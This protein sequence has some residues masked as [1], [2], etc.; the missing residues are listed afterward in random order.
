MDKIKRKIYFLR[1]SKLALSYKDHEAMPFKVLDDLSTSR[2][3]PGIDE[4]TTKKLLIDLDNKND[5]SQVRD[6]YYNSSDFQSKRSSATAKAVHDFIKD[7]YNI[8]CELV[9]LPEL[10]EI[11]FS[12]HDLVTEEEFESQGLPLLRDRLYEAI[13]ADKLSENA[14]E[15]YE[16]I[17]VIFNKVKKVGEHDSILITHN[18]F[19]RILEAYLT[20]TKDDKELLLND[21]LQTGINGYLRGFYV[22]EDLGNFIKI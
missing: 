4:V 15:I 6:I 10:H 8:E 7:K 3:E 13:L 18:F 22:N 20:K 1:H 17:R 11:N 16:R 12:L 5:L 19:M 9:K 2:L 21:I 14:S